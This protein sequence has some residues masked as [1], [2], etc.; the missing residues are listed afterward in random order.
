[1]RGT[2]RG[3]LIGGLGVG[4]IAGF[5]A[6]LFGVGGGILIV[7]G[8]VALGMRQRLAHGTSLAAIMPIAAAGIVG[9]WLEGSIDWP[10]AGL[11]AAAAAAGAVVGTHA[12]QRLE[13]RALRLGFVVIL[14]VT[15]G[16]LFLET[17]DRAGRGDLTILAVLGLLVLGLAAGVVAGLF[18]VGGGVI[19]VPALVIFLS[20]PDPVAKGT[21]LVVILPTAVVGTLRNL[22]HGNTDLA[23]AAGTGV[24]GVVSAF[25]ASQLAVRMDPRL[26]VVLFAGL[27]VAVAVR[28]LMVER[29]R[30]N[31]RREGRWPPKAGEVPPT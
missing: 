31:L 14:L 30:T 4:V 23:A 26:S 18:G 20:V 17:A 9:F 11:L 28:L 27:L 2:P 25:L 5:L 12:L 29:Q 24:A 3:R 8:L 15:A 19:I 16:R 6:G 21:S 13:G 7:P 10:V 1:M 22:R